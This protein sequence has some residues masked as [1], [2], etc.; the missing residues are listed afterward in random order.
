MSRGVF[1]AAFVPSNTASASKYAFMNSGVMLPLVS[2]ND[3]LI[4]IFGPAGSP[5]VITIVPVRVRIV[6]AISQAG[7]D[8]ATTLSK[9]V[10]ATPPFFSASQAYPTT[11]YRRSSAPSAFDHRRTTHQVSFRILRAPP[12]LRSDAGQNVAA[13]SRGV[14]ALRPPSA[15]F[16]IFEASLPSV[17]RLRLV[18][19]SLLRCH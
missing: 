3:P 10:F 2:S 7:L 18:I 13:I 17:G 6:N 12:P 9:A 11:L 5:D 15:T 16:P 14:K 4:L 1:G 19:G 8:H